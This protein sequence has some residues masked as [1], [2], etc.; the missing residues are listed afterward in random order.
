MCTCVFCQAGVSWSLWCRLS[1]LQPFQG[2]L[3]LLLGHEAAHHCSTCLKAL[4]DISL[5]SDST[6]LETS[7]FY[8]LGRWVRVS[9][10]GWALYWRHFC[11]AV[12]FFF[13]SEQVHGVPSSSGNEG[14]CTGAGDCPGGAPSHILVPLF[15][16]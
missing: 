2:V 12:L 5:C 9:F 10:R 14:G 1:S 8:H 3:G 11:A 7:G 13:G 6:W 16:Y 4:C 15:L